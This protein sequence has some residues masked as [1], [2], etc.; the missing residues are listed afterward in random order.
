MIETKFKKHI[1]LDIFRIKS[2]YSMY[3]FSIFNLLCDVP[4]EG[5]LLRNVSPSLVLSDHFPG[6]GI[7]EL[8]NRSVKE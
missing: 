5:V 8:G 7:F 1:V 4:K 2:R 6:G 3:L